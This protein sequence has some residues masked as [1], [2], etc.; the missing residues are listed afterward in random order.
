MEH[1]AAEKNAT[2]LIVSIQ[3]T[4]KYYQFIRQELGKAVATVLIVAQA[5]L[6]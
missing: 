6:D 5:R 4:K 3:R 1:M 2:W